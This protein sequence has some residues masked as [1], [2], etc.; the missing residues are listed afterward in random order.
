MAGVRGNRFSTPGKKVEVDR[1]K[2]VKR[3]IVT[4]EEVLAF[5]IGRGYTPRQL[6][7]SMYF[8]ELSRLPG[9][10][11]QLDRQFDLLT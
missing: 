10:G 1:P 5:L 7:N 2:Y 3:V 9:I 4:E 6:E 11:E 8:G